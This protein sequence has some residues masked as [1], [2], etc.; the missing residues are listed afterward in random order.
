MKSITINRLQEKSNEVH[1][2]FVGG[3][4]SAC[5][6][7]RDQNPSIDALKASMRQ[8]SLHCK[9]WTF[10]LANCSKK[11]CIWRPHHWGKDLSTISYIHF[12]DYTLVQQQ[13]QSNYLGTLFQSFSSSQANTSSNSSY[14]EIRVILI[15]KIYYNQSQQ[16]DKPEYKFRSDINMNLLKFNKLLKP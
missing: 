13:S 16:I 1:N 10:P 5:L 14:M 11:A 15:L 4:M 12:T 7:Q 6:R 3:T 8:S 9:T 2:M